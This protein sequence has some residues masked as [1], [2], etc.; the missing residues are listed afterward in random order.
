MNNQ[1]R[2]FC[3]KYSCQVGFD[4]PTMFMISREILHPAVVSRC[5]FANLTTLDSVCTQNF[6]IFEKFKKYGRRAKI[7]QVK[8]SGSKSA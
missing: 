3:Q 6:P 1:F 5:K 8:I 4:L 2:W 7:F